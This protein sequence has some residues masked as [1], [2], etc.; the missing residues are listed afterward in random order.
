MSMKSFDD[1]GFGEPWDADGFGRGGLSGARA[2]DAGAALSAAEH[3][4][5]LAFN[6][7]QSVRTRFPRPPAQRTAR[8][9]RAAAARTAHRGSA[10]A[11]LASGARLHHAR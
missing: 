11:A 4:G 3:L 7:G 6:L 9:A 10:H 8:P 2:L 1:P 5:R